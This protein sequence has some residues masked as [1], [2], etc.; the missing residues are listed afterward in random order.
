MGTEEKIGITRRW[1]RRLRG[2][3][4]LLFLLLPTLAIALVA[5]YAALSYRHAQRS[6]LLEEARTVLS[7]LVQH[8]P[9]TIRH[10]TDVAGIRAKWI[11]R[12]AE[13]PRRDP[14]ITYVMLRDAKGNDL[15][16]GKLADGPVATV[17]PGAGVVEPDLLSLSGALPV[18]HATARLKALDDAYVQIGLR[19]APGWANYAHLYNV[20]GILLVTLVLNVWMIRRGLR[21]LI[22]PLED[23]A[24]ASEGLAA[25]DTVAPVRVSGPDEVARLAESFNRMLSRRQKDRARIQN[26][27]ADLQAGQRSLAEANRALEEM[28]Q[29]LREEHASAI[30]EQRRF[31]AMVEGLQEGLIYLNSDGQVEYANPEAGRLLMEEAS[32]LRTRR[33][34]LEAA[35]SSELSVP[36]ILAQLVGEERWQAVRRQYELELSTVAVHSDEGEVR[37][38]MILLRDR[39]QERRLQRRLAEQDKIATVG[40]LAA[41]IAHEINNPLDGLQNCLRRIVNDPANAEQIERYAGLMT[42]SLCHIG[43]V[44][45]QLLDLSHKRDRMVRRIDIN[46]TLTQAVEL[47]KAGQRWN[48]LRTEM[49]LA[50]NLPLVLADPQNLT[51]VFL[52]LILN[53]VDAMPDGGTLTL[54]TGTAPDGANGDDDHHVVVEVADT[55]AGIPTDTLS[56]IFEPFFTTKSREKGTGLGLSVS[57]NLVIEHGGDIDV[58]STPG[59]GTRFRVIL[60]RFFAARNLRPQKENR[61]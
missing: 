28:T 58:E 54:R 45:R 21:R 40:V 33:T 8:H 48:G 22:T 11:K 37:G 20:L 2:S 12:I 61:G 25:G 35:R 27:L 32:S 31:L 24:D 18:A 16:G 39:S 1:P 55:G 19:M 59:R 9:A 41:G 17:R 49:R 13:L 23:L 43:T 56:R 26:T 3:L 52:N 10:P 4:T 51:Q 34:T 15:S 6:A 57:R 47:A 29:S 5:G 60:P 7:L 36:H 46:E 30:F 44:I 53:A 42:A 38:R 14:R 50:D